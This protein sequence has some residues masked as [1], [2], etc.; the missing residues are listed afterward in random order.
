M[1]GPIFRPMDLSRLI[2][3]KW[4]KNY[5]LAELLIGNAFALILGDWM[6]NVFF[7]NRAGWVSDSLV[8]MVYYLDLF[9]GIFCTV[10]LS[11]L[12]LWYEKP[13]HRCL[14]MFHKGETP[15]SDLLET[16]R[17][18]VLNAPFFIVILDGAVWGIGAF[19]FRAAGFPGGLRVGLGS[20]LI[21][22]SLAFF[23]VEHTSQFFRIPLFFPEGGLSGIPGVKSI[24]LG[25]R[26]FALF[27]A[28]SFVPLSFIH[29]TIQRYRHMQ[30]TSEVPLAD[31]L[32]GLEHT[33]M[34]E[35]A[36]FMA[37]SVG[38]SLLVIQHLRRPVKE[39]IKIMDF[40]KQGDFSKKARVF[41]NDEIGF[42]GETLNA[43]NQGLMEREKIKDTFGQYVAPQIRDEILSGRV[44]LDGDRKEATILFADLRNFTPLV[45]VTPAKDL[46]YLL[47]SYFD[48]VFQ[49]IESHGGLILQF[50]GDEAEA[51]FGAPV[52]RS[53]HE[54][55]ALNA[56]LELRIRLL[57]LNEKFKA[58]G[59][60]TVTHGIGIN[61]G[62]VF[63][64]RV[65]NAERS[66][67]SL[68]GD[69]VNMASRIQDLT[70]TFKTDILVSQT[71]Y[72][73]LKDRY[74]FK[75]MPEIHVQ[76]KDTPIQVYALA[77]RQPVT[78]A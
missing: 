6:T 48:E 20:G 42:A 70:K 46:I 5:L 57:Q 28:V 56:A 26:F 17:R 31:V 14:S 53:G 11:T 10:I 62:P 22:V 21:T 25:V 2:K 37:V 29:L 15:A 8:G 77:D 39:I 19:L 75:V 60:P 45:A 9:Y 43:M 27:C 76:G 74:D 13:V 30:M 72:D 54:S 61:T 49:A 51:V 59:L 63:A 35:S 33:I 67:Y 23:W 71:M 68:I 50:I 40:V 32:Y 73:A 69:T 7:L 44:S 12:I 3:N 36:I 38:L 34:V 58:K 41:T 65:G 16:A 18:R 66:A 24:S 55:D 64:A 78:Y 47:N 52:A 1:A 4:F